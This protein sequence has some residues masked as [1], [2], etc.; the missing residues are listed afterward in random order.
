MRKI[1]LSALLSACLYSNE[2]FTNYLIYSNSITEKNKTTRFEELKLNSQVVYRENDLTLQAEFL[3]V[4]PYSEKPKYD[5]IDDPRIYNRSLTAEYKVLDDVAI[6]AGTLSFVDDCYMDSQ[7]IR[8]DT[9]NNGIPTLV[10]TTYDGVFVSK[11]INDEDI[12]KV[13]YGAYNVIDVFNKEKFMI[14]ENK[15]SHGLFVLA[16]HHEPSNRRVEF[17]FYDISIHYLDDPIGD[18]YL[19]GVSWL[20]MF[21]EEGI[22]LYSSLGVSHLDKK[23]SESTVIKMMEHKEIPTYAPLFRPEIFNFKNEKGTGYAVMLGASKEF[24]YMKSI[25][26]GAEYYYASKDYMNLVSPASGKPY[27]YDN[28]GEMLRLYSTLS[29]NKNLTVMICGYWFDRQYTTRIGGLLGED[30]VPSEVPDSHLS[31]TLFSTTVRWRF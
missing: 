7:T 17:N 22:E 13:G 2:T 24:D 23:M 11:R 30:N 29:L 16:E 31:E 4:K 1:L 18:L 25:K 6:T 19:G 14:Y 28:R 5:E 20:E 12:I 10:Q 26:V 9:R 15:G 8:E 21:P 3:I 27:S